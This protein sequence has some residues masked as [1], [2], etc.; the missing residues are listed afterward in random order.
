MV[1]DPPQDDAPHPRFRPDLVDERA[2]VRGEL[3]Q[4]QA[5]ILG[6]GERRRHGCGE[7]LL[8]CVRLEGVREECRRGG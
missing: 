6:D 1:T 5:P 2:V 4:W 7:V 8:Q 3:G